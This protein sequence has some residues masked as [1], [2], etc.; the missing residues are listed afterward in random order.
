MNDISEFKGTFEEILK[1]MTQKGSSNKQKDRKSNKILEDTLKRMAQEGL[2]VPR[3]EN[4]R[5]LHVSYKG[6]GGLISK[7]WNIKI[8]TSG[9]IVC[10]DLSVIRKFYHDNLKPPNKNLNLIQI[11][12]A[13]IGFPLGGCMVGVCCDDEVL[14]DVV[15]VSYFRPGPFDR[16]DYLKE[17]AIRGF[18]I[19]T[20]L[21]NATPE[22]HRIEICTGHI[23]SYLR[24]ILVFMG[25]DVRLVDIKGLLQDSLEDLFKNHIKDLVGKDLAYDP[26]ELS[27]SDIVNGYHKAVQW[28]INNA[29]HLLKTGWD[30]LRY[31]T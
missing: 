22:T 26:K 19:A 8:Y 29:P 7:K 13:G 3:K 14:T 31:L 11:D 12:D 4:N 25:Y 15:D 5:Y 27:S 10:L 17:Y 24:A 21:F 23:N 30:S 16:K 2:I 1:R 28:G 18:Y 6:T 20:E 9:K